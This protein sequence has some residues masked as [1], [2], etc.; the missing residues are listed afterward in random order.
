MMLSELTVLSMIVAWYNTV[1]PNVQGKL[2]AN[3]N[4]EPTSYFFP[5]RE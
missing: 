4:Y 2:S 3:I 1:K 5:S